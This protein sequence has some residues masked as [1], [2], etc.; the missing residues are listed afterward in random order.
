M[1]IALAVL[2]PFLA[3]LGGQAARAS[4]YCPDR[5][6]ID[7]PPCTIDRGHLSVEAS[8]A[9]WTHANDPDST[10]DTLLLGDLAL[11]YGIGERT[12][13][14]LAWTPYGHVRIRDRASGDV[15]SAS[16]SGDVTLGIKHNILD[17]GAE[18]LSIALLPSITLPAG[19]EAIGAG[20]WSAH[21][22]IPVSLAAGGGVSLLLTPEIDAAANGDGSGRHLAYG[23][24]G[25]VAF[26]PLAHLNIALE[27]A[28]MHDEEPAGPA[29]VERAGAS[30]GL[31]LSQNFQ[32]DFGAEFGL[33]RNAPDH[34]F[35][36]GI[37]RRF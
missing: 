33:N 1:R 34:R 13:A 21:L 27:A 26:S 19:G 16:G 7:T 20:T 31:M 22:Q 3:L 29:T 36:L 35:Y 14:R 28:V 18:H 8:L 5:P 10:V 6:G 9:D 23:T 15:A 25:G 12:E 11:R 37:A 4:D 30:A 17:P 24:A 32:I 2:L